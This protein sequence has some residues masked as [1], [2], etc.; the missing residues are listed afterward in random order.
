MTRRFTPSGLGTWTVNP[1]GV[2]DDNDT[3]DGSRVTLS[4]AESLYPTQWVPVYYDPRPDR[5][6]VTRDPE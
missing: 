5:V 1:S 2:S 4:S 3:N 6:L